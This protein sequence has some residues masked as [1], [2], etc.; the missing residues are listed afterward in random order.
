MKFLKYLLIIVA[1]LA[2]IFFGKGLLTPQVSYESEIV[3]NKPVNEA[4]AIM[5][6]ESRISE[7][8]PGI[9]KMELISGTENK[10]GAV[11]KIY[12]EEN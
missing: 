8:L 6:D 3:V 9:K 10:V 12:F 2:I 11:S 4:W 7:W 1:L 5:S